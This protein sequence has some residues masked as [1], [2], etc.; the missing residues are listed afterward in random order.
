[1]KHRPVA[2][3]ELV[4]GY[5]TAAQLAERRRD[6][7]LGQGDEVE[8]KAWDK[9]A[10]YCRM[11][12]QFRMLD[13]PDAKANY[14]PIDPVKLDRLV[15]REIIDDAETGKE[16]SWTTYHQMALH[17]A[18]AMLTPRERMASY[19]YYAGQMKR[20]DIANAMEITLQTLDT[21]IRRA[22]KKWTN[23]REDQDLGTQLY[24]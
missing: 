13:A 4:S 16:Q 15:L 20:E 21:L 7:V 10:R 23:L 8:A 14:T 18:L 2:S 6:E 19:M 9:I 22:R 3:D 1:V 12:A 24:P 17:A 11:M 5:D